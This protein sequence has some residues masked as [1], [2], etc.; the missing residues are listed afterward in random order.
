SPNHYLQVSPDQPPR[1]ELTSPAGNIVATIGRKVELAFRGRDDHGVVK[2]VVAYRV[3]K[4]EEEKILFNPAKPID[5]VEQVIDWD[6]RAVLTNLVVGQAVSLAVELADAYPGE[7]GPHRARSETRRIQFMTMEDYL[8]QVE[9]QQKR[10]LSQLRSIYREEREV[11]ETVMRLDR[12]DPIFIQTCQLEAVRQDLMRERIKKLAASMDELTQDLAA[13][14]ITNLALTA[15]LDQLRSDLLVISDQHVSEAAA[16]MRALASD[17]ARKGADTAHAHAAQRVNSSARELGLLVLHLGFEDAADVMGREMHAAA[18]T[19]A[20]LRLRTIMPGSKL[21]ELVEAQENL[22]QWLTRLFAASPKGKESRIEDA[23]IEFTLTRIV[24]QLVNGGVALQLQ[25]AA[26]LIGEDKSSDAARIQSDVVAALL[27]AEFR[28]RVGSEREALAKAMALFVS[29]EDAQKTLRLE[30]KALDE[31]SF[32]KR[33]KEMAAAQAALHRNLQLLL[34]PAIPAPRTRL[35]DDTIPS[36]PRV[37]D[38]LA[39]A[40]DALTRAVSGIE[41]EDLVAAEKA[42]LNAEESFAALAVMV[43]KRIAAMTQAVR[44]ERLTY[45]AKETDERLGRIAE[46]QLSLL[47]KTE[48][49]AADGSK[50]DYLADQESAVVAALDELSLEIADRVSQAGTPSEESPSLP[51]SIGMALESMR[52]TVPLL[53]DNRPGVAAEHQESAVSTLSVAR[54]ILAEH[55]SNISAFAAMLSGTKTAVAPSPYVAEIEE[56]QRDMLDLT[57]KTKPEDLPALAIPQKNLTHAVDAILVALDPI[58]HLVESGTVML[59]AKDDM[60]AAGNA[61]AVKDPVE[62]LDAQT[63]II[64]TLAALRGK[65]DAVI[66]Q[67]RYLLEITEALHETIPEGILIREAQRALR[68]K[69]TDKTDA[70][71]LV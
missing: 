66:P 44:I 45:G 26:T 43:R 35:F 48:D 22:G 54:D 15:S 7:N 47:E 18:Q 49:A 14:S 2:S 41:K 23:L 38:L 32:K 16:A 21:Q 65:I 6:Y 5:G 25:K 67:Y 51:I 30:I 68:E 58:S 42:Q 55:G 71:A 59:F 11:Y 24:K 28:L 31:K 57:S 4:T 56:E 17:S 53:A 29:Q 36:A 62:A 63:F 60:D 1:V 69:A 64:E 34:M 20:A 52:K 33:R 61:M 8:A 9:K 3:D 37:H 39:N 12:S 70:A 10:L 13:N 27:Q 46:R 40:D 19:Q 50:S